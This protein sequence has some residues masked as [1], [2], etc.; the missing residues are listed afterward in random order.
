MRKEKLQQLRKI[1]KIVCRTQATLCFTL[2]I[3]LLLYFHWN[4]YWHG[5]KLILIGLFCLYEDK[6]WS[7]VGQKEY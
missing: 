1:F 4:T 6:L 5:L 7:L 3:I 2:G